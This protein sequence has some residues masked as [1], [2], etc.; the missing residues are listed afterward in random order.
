MPDCLVRSKCLL[1]RQGRLAEALPYWQQLCEADDAEAL[2]EAAKHYEWREVDL[3]RALIYAQS[4]LRLSSDLV[5]R[6]AINHRIERLERKL[7]DPKR[8]S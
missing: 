8:A 4:A 3:P 6:A 7:K 5:A 1:K 2:I